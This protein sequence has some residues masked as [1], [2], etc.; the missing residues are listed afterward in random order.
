M[1]YLYAK[2]SLMHVNG[3]FVFLFFRLDDLGRIL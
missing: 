1:N 2:G 3:G